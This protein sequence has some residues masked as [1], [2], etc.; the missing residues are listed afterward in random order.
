LTSRLKRRLAVAEGTAA[1]LEVT[2]LSKSIGGVTVLDGIDLR[3]ERGRVYGLSG[4]N[5]SGKTMLMRVIAGL[6]HPTHGT[7][8]VGGRLLGRDCSFPASM[9]ILIENPSFINKHTGF[10]NL[11]MLASL[12]GKVGDDE[13][14]EA[15]RSVGLDPFDRRSYRKYSL[16]MRQRLGIAA[17]V[18]E[19]PELVILDEPFNSL[20]EDGCALIRSLI[21][22]Q[23]DRGALVILACHDSAQLDSLADEAFCLS[24]GRLVLS[25]CGERSGGQARPDS[26]PAGGQAQP[27]HEGAREH[28]RPPQ[29]GV[30]RHART[31]PIGARRH[32]RHV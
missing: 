28:G 17:A 16:G 4:I 15:L 26:A 32:G 12:Q 21:L 29:E 7:V 25:G 23:R 3:M 30:P 1:Y 31:A 9:G 24:G 27:L 14:R 19:S 13:V 8:R 20:D 10:K 11:K 6:A 18:M 5:G 2:G 22:E